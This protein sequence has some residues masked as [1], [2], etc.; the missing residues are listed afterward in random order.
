VA[1]STRN[2]FVMEAGNTMTADPETAL[3]S[4][5]LE[6]CTVLGVAG[7]IALLLFVL[8]Q[9]GL[10]YVSLGKPPSPTPEARPP[11][12]P[13]V[14]IE[15]TPPPQLTAGREDDRRQSSSV[16]RRKQTKGGRKP[17]GKK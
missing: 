8:V 13:T 1:K 11:D 10:F 6:H 15:G 14:T 5:F 7:L 2:P 12:P 16:R 4:F 17:G 9:R 3:I